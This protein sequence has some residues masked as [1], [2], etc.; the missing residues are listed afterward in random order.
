MKRAIMA[1][2]MGLTLGAWVA[3][4]GGGI[5]AEGDESS[6][7]ATLEQ[8]LAPGEVRC[9]SANPF[10]RFVSTSQ[11]VSPGVYRFTTTL[12]GRVQEWG[13]L[14]FL[15][16]STGEL[17]SDKE[18]RVT[19]TLTKGTSGPRVWIWTSADNGSFSIPFTCEPAFQ[20]GG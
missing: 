19:G 2:S 7:L 4:C 20:T 8:A 16:S 14:H 15:E 5:P 1:M 12:D 13:G 9:V 3:G 11:L 17:Y 6:A 10:W 18:R